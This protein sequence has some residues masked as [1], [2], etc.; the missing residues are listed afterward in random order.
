MNVE[1]LPTEILLEIL[2][3]F[4]DKTLVKVVRLINKK[5]RAI[6]DNDHL[7]KKKFHQINVYNPLWSDFWK[8][9]WK[10][11]YISCQLWRKKTPKC[12][13]LVDYKIK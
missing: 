7:W 10:T 13:R 1:D 3:Y 9:N 2:L 12:G 6:V 4:D 5:F 8:N 11:N